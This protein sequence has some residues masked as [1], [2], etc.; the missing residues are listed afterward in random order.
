M[1][2]DV[3]KSRLFIWGSATPNTKSENSK[4]SVEAEAVNCGDYVIYLRHYGLAQL[5]NYSTHYITQRLSH[6]NVT[7]DSGKF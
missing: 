2:L 7:Y 5:P 6:Q 1:T 3:V 4:I